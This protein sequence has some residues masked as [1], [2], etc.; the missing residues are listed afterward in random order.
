VLAAIGSSR[1]LQAAPPTASALREADA[2]FDYHLEEVARSVHGGMPF[3]PGGDDSEYSVQIWGRT[4]THLTAPPRA[5]AVAGGAG[6]LRSRVNGCRLRVYT[7]QTPSTPS[8]SRRTSMRA[9]PRAHA[10]AAAVTPVL[11]LAPLLMLAVGA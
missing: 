6:L 3:A 5:A 11:L 10:G 2:M 7:L 8:R 4:A 1:V 9:R